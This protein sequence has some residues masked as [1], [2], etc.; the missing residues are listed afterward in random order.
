VYQSLLIAYSICVLTGLRIHAIEELVPSD[1]TFT[2]VHFALFNVLETLLGIL[3]TCLPVLR[4]VLK[5][6]PIT[7]SF[8]W[9]KNTKET[10]S[11]DARSYQKTWYRRNKVPSSY[12]SKLGDP[13]FQRIDEHRYPL[14]EITSVDGHNTVKVG[15]ADTSTD[16]IEGLV[17]FTS[18]DT[19]NKIR[20][21]QD[22][23][24][25]SH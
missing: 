6:I 22:W 8:S 4:P 5:K 13:D 24:V 17:G 7:K 23:Q 18:D 12:R 1:I 11:S 2:Q 25:I 9:T 19:V 16:D 14:N 10:G 3:N 21:T 20:V 15:R